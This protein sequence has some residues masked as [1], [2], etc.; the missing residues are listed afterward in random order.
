MKR[1]RPKRL[2]RH[3]VPKRCRISTALEDRVNTLV[4]KHAL[5]IKNLELRLVEEEL[6]N[7]KIQNRTGFSPGN[8]FV[9]GVNGTDGE[10]LVYC[11][12][13]SAECKDKHPSLCIGC[14]T[15]TL[16][17][18]FPIKRNNNCQ[19]WLD[20]APKQTVECV[21]HNDM[22]LDTIK[23]CNIGVVDFEI[24][25][26]F[27]SFPSIPV[28]KRVCDTCGD[29]SLDEASIIPH[30]LM[31]CEFSTIHAHTLTCRHCNSTVNH[32]HLGY[33]MKMEC[34]GYTCLL[35]GEKK[36]GMIEANKCAAEHLNS[37]FAKEYVR[38]NAVGE[39]VEEFINANLS[40]FGEFLV[41]NKH[42]SIQ[43]AIRKYIMTKKIELDAF[44]N[45]LFS[46]HVFMMSQYL[47]IQKHLGLLKQPI[48]VAR[49][50]GL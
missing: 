3:N 25:E 46:D 30:I 28:P 8:C 23:Q 40:N 50:L 16:R 1:T 15:P 44:T 47:Y 38:I 22:N 27:D 42:K 10:P 12:K 36:T 49:A 2:S 43:E 48:D 5:T 39:I 33:H 4:S 45:D 17:P 24:K 7:K 32:E 21:H 13:E 29:D 14:I 18:Q 9:C 41:A 20:R 37:D 6:R 34:T 11:C 19:H 35:C 26:F 31:D